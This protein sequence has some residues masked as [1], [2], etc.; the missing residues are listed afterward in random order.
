MVDD[1]APRILL[2]SVVVRVYYLTAA[3]LTRLGSQGTNAD[4][5]KLNV[6][7]FSKNLPRFTSI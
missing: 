7:I 5:S 6:L 4:L 2:L 3:L 1:S